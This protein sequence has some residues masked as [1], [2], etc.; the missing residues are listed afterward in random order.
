MRVLLLAAITIDGKI[1][2]SSNEIIDWSSPEDK[3]MFM[4]VSQEAG[5]LIMG[6]RTYETLKQPLPDR[7]HVVLTHHTNRPRPE[8]VE[9][10]SA[11]PALIVAD[12]QKRGF[13]TAILAGGA[14]IYRSFIDARLVDELWLTVEPLAFGSGISL[15]GDDPLNLRLLLVQSELLNESSLQLRYRIL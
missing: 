2:R 7:L 15:L 9:F 8:H 12:L 10:T 11:T 14:R 5:V 1:A 3:R 6:L 13:E 4:Q